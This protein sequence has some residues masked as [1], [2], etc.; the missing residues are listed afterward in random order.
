M[1]KEG[2][3]IDKD[4][5]VGDKSENQKRIRLECGTDWTEQ[6]VYKYDDKAYLCK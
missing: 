5:K 2:L 4:R 3:N 1:R 6:I